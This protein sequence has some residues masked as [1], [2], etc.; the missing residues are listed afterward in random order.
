[1]VERHVLRML[2]P[3]AATSACGPVELKPQSVRL[4]PT[5]VTATTS[6]WAAGYATQSRVAQRASYPWLP[7]A[8]TTSCPLAA[9][10]RTASR[11]TCEGVGE[12][13]LRLTTVWRGAW[14]AHHTIPAATSEAEPLPV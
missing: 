2:S 9:A 12:P 14:S 7:A 10:Y 6:G 3:G 5:Q 4:A 1:M 13:R 8:A 11:M